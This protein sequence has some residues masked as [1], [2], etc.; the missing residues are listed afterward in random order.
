MNPR[1]AQPAMLIVTRSSWVISSPRSMAALV[2]S[3]L[4]VC[5]VAVVTYQVASPPIRTSAIPNAVTQ[6]RRRDFVGCPTAAG[7]V[8]GA[9]GSPGAVSGFAVVMVSLSVVVWQV[10]L[11]GG[12]DE[13]VA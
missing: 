8:L 12:D 11:V 2:V 6:S 9:L 7:R 4:T 10:R 5:E 13:E 1:P 3:T